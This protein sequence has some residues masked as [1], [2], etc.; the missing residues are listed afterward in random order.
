MMSQKAGALS[1]QTFA[2]GLSL[3]VFL[4]FDWA[5]ERF[6]S[7]WNPLTTLGRNAIACYIAHGFL[8]DAISSGW[9]QKTSPESHVLLGLFLVLSA[10]FGLAK[11]LEWRGIF[12]RL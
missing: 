12:L 1:Y 11:F 6:R 5:S 8:I 7:R 2:G 3:L 4:I 10:T 9:L